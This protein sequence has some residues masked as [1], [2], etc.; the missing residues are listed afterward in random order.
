MITVQTFAETKNIPDKIAV[1]RDAEG[2]R[3]YQRGDVVPASKSAPVFPVLTGNQLCAA[4][5][6]ASLRA[7]VEAIIADESTDQT[8]KDFWQRTTAFRREH[9]VVNQLAQ[10]LG[11]TP[12]QVDTLWLQAAVG[13]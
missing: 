12:E 9:P 13:S 3:V 11:L 2:Y 8:V 5:N 7:G 4:L 10:A 6:S 1:K